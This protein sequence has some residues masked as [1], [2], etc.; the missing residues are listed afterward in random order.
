MSQ[1]PIHVSFIPDPQFLSLRTEIEALLPRKR[2]KWH[3]LITDTDG[4]VHRVHFANGKLLY[5]NHSKLISLRPLSE[6]NRLNIVGHCD[7]RYPELQR[8]LF[9]ALERGGWEAALIEHTRMIDEAATGNHR[10][11]PHK[12]SIPTR[13]GEPVRS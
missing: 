6:R 5:K 13:P 7:P 3:G 9:G 1:E 2:S 11:K 8:R 4:V 12:I 10:S